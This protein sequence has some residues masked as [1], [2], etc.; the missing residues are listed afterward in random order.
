M[1][2]I[3]QGQVAQVLNRTLGFRHDLVRMSD[4]DT[5]KYLRKA[6]RKVPLEQ[7][8]GLAENFGNHYIKE[9]Q[10]QYELLDENNEDEG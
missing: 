3:G 5:E 6:M 7:F 9:E 8:I 10:A 2:D 4:N 1:Q